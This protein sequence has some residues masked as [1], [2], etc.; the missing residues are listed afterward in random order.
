MG[1]E[2]DDFIENPSFDKLELCCKDDLLA[3]AAHFYI[4]VQKYGVK[5]EIKNKVWK[6]LL[7]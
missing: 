4:P 7:E 3:I 2:L 6:K 1:F 5:R